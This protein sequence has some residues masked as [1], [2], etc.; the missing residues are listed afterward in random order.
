MF[1]NLINNLFILD[2]L[3][4]AIPVYEIEHNQ[5]MVLH[6]K[7]QEINPTIQPVYSTTNFIPF[8]SKTKITTQDLIQLLHASFKFSKYISS[9]ELMPID[10]TTRVVIY[11]EQFSDIAMRCLQN[12][13]NCDVCQYLKYIKL[14]SIPKDHLYLL[15]DSEMFGCRFVSENYNGAFCFPDRIINLQIKE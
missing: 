1:E 10:F 7:N 5:I 2:N 12:F 15:P 14:E 9:P 3:G 8:S 6:D 11:G 13:A 4:S